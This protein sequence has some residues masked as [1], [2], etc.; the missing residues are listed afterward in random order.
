MNSNQEVFIGKKVKRVGLQRYLLSKISYE[1]EKVV[2]ADLVCLYENQLWLESKARKDR[3]FFEKFGP[4][5]EVCTILM[6]QLNIQ[7]GLNSRA[8]LKFS[9]KIKIECESF[10]F[11]PRNFRAMKSKFSGT[12]TPRYQRP[13]GT[14]NKL[15]PPIK[16]IGKGYG[17]KGTAQIPE[18]DASPSWQDVATAVS[19]KERTRYENFKRRIDSA[20][21]IDEL[22]TIFNEL[23]TTKDDETKPSERRG[24]SHPEKASAGT[25]KARGS[26]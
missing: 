13:A 9:A 1:V 2:L 19:N 22:E 4:T 15:L 5:L 8:L 20:K 12:Y 6:K 26:W 3:E 7:H 11:P 24:D 10:L 25:K 14:P 17:D 23:T 21:N 16:F 18:L